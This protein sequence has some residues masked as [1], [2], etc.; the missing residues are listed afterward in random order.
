MRLS[1][2]EAFYRL[3]NRARPSLPF[4]FFFLTRNVHSSGNSKTY[5]MSSGVYVSELVLSLPVTIFPFKM[6][7]LLAFFSYA[8]LKGT[9]TD[10]QNPFPVVFSVSFGLSLV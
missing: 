7:L 8:T 6:N 1:A 10:H 5:Y 2:L 9:A 3:T 4:L